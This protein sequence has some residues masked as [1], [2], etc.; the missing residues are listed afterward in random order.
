MLFSGPCFI[1]ISMHE[2]SIIEGMIDLVEK[3]RAIHHFKKV[4]EIH[5]ACGIYNC[6][7]E[8]NLNFCLKT[9]AQGTCLEGVILKVHRLPERWRCPSC[10]MDFVVENKDVEACCPKCRSSSVLPLL[11]S[12]ILLD[13]LEVE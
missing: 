3:Q 9:V 7:S 5:L 13:K 8:E 2:V 6:V 4:Q 10:E 12:E 1:M 11:N